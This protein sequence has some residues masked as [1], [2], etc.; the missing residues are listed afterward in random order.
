MCL[1]LEAKHT[2]RN[3]AAAVLSLRILNT[4]HV[5]LIQE[6]RDT[7][8]TCRLPLR[9]K[10]LGMILP[11]GYKKITLDLDILLLFFPLQGCFRNPTADHFLDL[12][13]WL[14]SC[15]TVTPGSHCS[16]LMRTPFHQLLQLVRVF[17]EDVPLY[18]D[19]Y[20]DTLVLCYSPALLS[21]LLEWVCIGLIMHLWALYT[22]QV[23]LLHA[24]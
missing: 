18:P 11:L 2:R 24:Q 17:R 22:A 13:T 7:T 4:G 14:L 19:S 1:I 9:L 21:R 5:S 20:F 16:R 6:P 12:A 8:D 3:M 15:R 10:C 23:D